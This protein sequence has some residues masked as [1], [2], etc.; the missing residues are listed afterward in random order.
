VKNLAECCCGC[1]LRPVP[2]RK[3][4]KGHR[5]L[6]PTRQGYR[7]VTDHDGTTILEH[8]KVLRDA[9]VDLP[10]GCHVHHVNGDKLDNR[11]ENLE[12]I[13]VREHVLHH[14]RERGYVVNQ[15]GIWPLNEGGEHA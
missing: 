9:G 11:L 14:A 15:F 1:G 13:S 4:V 3:Y 5:P 12:V 2:G 7:R 10:R 8:R 6:K